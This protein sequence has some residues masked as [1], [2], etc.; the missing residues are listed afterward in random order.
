MRRDY[1]ELDVRDVDWYEDDGDPRQPTVSIDFYG[2]AEE[3]RSRFL[4]TSGDVVAAEELDVSFRLQ[5]SV[6]DDD[7]RG[8]VSVTDRLTGDYVLELN[9][10]A[11]DVL[12]FIRAAREYGRVAGDDEGRYRVDVAIES[13][14]FETFEKSTFLVYDGD[15][16]LLRSQSLIPSG[17]EL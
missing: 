1:F 12:D 11:E 13:D 6:D 14:H 15:G 8:V 17:V 7:A 10:R 9:A 4:S 16:T 5:D 3:L 2:P